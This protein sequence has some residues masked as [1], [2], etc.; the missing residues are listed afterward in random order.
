M[1]EN[2]QKQVRSSIRAVTVTRPETF[3]YF[4]F[5]CF[6]PYLILIKI[7]REK[8]KIKKT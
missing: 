7:I 2:S 4:F 8:R 1:P 5:P 6:F 3:F